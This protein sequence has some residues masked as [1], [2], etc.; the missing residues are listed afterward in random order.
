LVVYQIATPYGLIPGW[1]NSILVQ[2]RKQINRPTRNPAM[3][4]ITTQFDVGGARRY[5]K[6][7]GTIA[8]NKSL[9]VSLDCFEVPQNARRARI[10]AEVDPKGECGS[11]DKGCVDEGGGATESN[12]Q[13]DRAVSQQP[14][15]LS[16]C[17]KYGK[18]LPEK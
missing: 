18:T 14:G 17:V 16:V 8:D 10:I 2:V 11:P 3:V 5:A 7:W 15:T 1:E 13:I 6:Q 12:N 4:T 9:S